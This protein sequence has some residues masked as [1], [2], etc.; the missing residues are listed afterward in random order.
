[1]V[2]QLISRNNVGSTQ[3]LYVEYKVYKKYVGMYIYFHPLDDA[4][5]T[6]KYRNKDN[7]FSTTSSRTKL[8]GW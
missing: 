2:V 7:V 3:L 6:T 1:M 5:V 8:N 4:F